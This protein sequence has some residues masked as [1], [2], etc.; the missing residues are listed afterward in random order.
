MSMRRILSKTPT[1]GHGVITAVVCL[2]LAAVVAAMASLNVAM[3]DIARDTHATQTQLLWVIDAYSLAFAALLLPGGALGDRYGRRAALIAGLV[4]FGAG[5][6]VAITAS[7]ATELIAL[8]AVLGL[9][10]ALVMPA[11]LSTITGTFPPAER[12]RAVS[13]W[14][15]VAGGAAILGL[16]A[17]GVLLA[18]SS[19]RAIFGLNVA[20]SVVALAGTM[21][22]VPESADPDAP[23][24]DVGGALISVLALV[25]LVFS[26]I[27]APTYG[28]LAARTVVGLAAA[29]GLLVP[30][31]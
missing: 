15:A 20:L 26:V 7:S 30:R 12:T 14:A 29:G 8:R 23:R 16:L 31:S 13:V 27:E 2:A 17:S 22:F 19:W 6:A 10:A 21:R 3:P 25:A 24:L 18:I 11:T 4:I 9:G 5:S 1:S 28:W